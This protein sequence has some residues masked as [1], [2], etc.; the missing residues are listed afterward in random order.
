LSQVARSAGTLDKSGNSGR[1]MRLGTGDILYGQN[2]T[3]FQGEGHLDGDAS[4]SEGLIQRDYLLAVELRV[5][6]GVR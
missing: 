2:S 5:G 3:V 4:D 1:S 6:R